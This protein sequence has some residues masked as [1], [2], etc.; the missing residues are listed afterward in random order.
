LTHKKTV[1]VLLG[2]LVGFHEIV[3]QRDDES[4]RRVITTPWTKSNMCSKSGDQV[5]L[6]VVK[7]RSFFGIGINTLIAGRLSFFWGFEGVERVITFV[8][9][10]YEMRV[11]FELGSRCGIW[12]GERRVS[13]WRTV[14][15]GQSVVLREL[16]V[17][18]SLH[19]SK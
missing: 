8:L 6:E 14:V 18:L 9:N 11:F 4:V 5:F 3:P 12:G 7:N 1:K 16:L 19:P 15:R 10:F 17:W 2:R 13:L